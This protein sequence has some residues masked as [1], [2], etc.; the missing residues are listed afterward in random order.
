MAKIIVITEINSD[1]L[2]QVLNQV[3]PATNEC[4]FQAIQVA[5][6]EMPQSLKEF[7][8]GLGEGMRNK[9]ENK[10]EKE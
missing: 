6:V 8:A 7:L 10:K 1:Q 9:K 4:P 3:F 5:Q 2:Q